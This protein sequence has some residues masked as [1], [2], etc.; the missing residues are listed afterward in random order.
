MLGA[1]ESRGPGRFQNEHD[2]APRA[3]GPDLAPDHGCAWWIAAGEGQPQCNR[4]LRGPWRTQRLPVIASGHYKVPPGT[5]RN[6]PGTAGRQGG[7]SGEPRGEDDL[8]ERH[9]AR[10]IVKPQA[11]EV[12]VIPTCEASDLETVHGD[13]HF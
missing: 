6:E 8:F 1:K 11:L 7:L 4:R 9:V 12:C 3:G 10:V 13:E 2:N 5:P